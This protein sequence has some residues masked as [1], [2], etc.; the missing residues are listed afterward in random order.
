M[1]NK[2]KR[3]LILLYGITTSVILT[4]IL[5]GISVMNYRQSNEQD[6]A[7]LRKNVEQ[8]VEKIQ[9]DNII[10]NTWM[11]QMEKENHLI[12]V[13]EENG[14]LLLDN[15]RTSTDLL[16]E[17][18]VGQIKQRAEEEGIHLDRKP[19]YS[20]TEKTS[21]LTLDLGAQGTY[22]AEA[23]VI[24]K[25]SGWQSIM[26]FTGPRSIAQAGQILIMIFIDLIGAGALFIISSLY[27]GSV[28]RPLEE[29]Q[30]KQNAFV[31]AASHEL[32]SPLTV[33]KTGAASI[34]E[35]VTK[36]DQF[37]PHVEREC[38]RMSRLINDMLLLAAADAKTWDLNKEP[39][40]MDTLMIECYDMICTCLNQNGANIALDL[41][42]KALNI[43]EGDRERMKQILTILVENAISHACKGDSI[44]IRAYNQKHSVVL[45]VEDHGD[46]I[47]DEEKKR[48]FERFYRGDQSRSEKKHFGLGL[49][50]AKELV[51]L[52]QG[53]ITIRDTQGGGATFIVRLPV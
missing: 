8:I 43:V 1:F 15:S 13:I 30:R 41:P 40:D 38:D 27:I 48:V 36:A 49:S 37:L 18:L 11:L 47:P 34:R 45:E 44:I 28:I 19:M 39:V 16:K 51:E 2:L 17:P 9:S 3:K 7:L 5:L 22:F 4:I 14:K 6:R 53:D 33:I 52:H 29:G 46:G 23:I 12:I 31:A 35:D 42:Q 26:I 50:I 21:V 24:P 32:R 25:E 20:R 10:N